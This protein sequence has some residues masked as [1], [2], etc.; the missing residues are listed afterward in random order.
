M[1]ETQRNVVDVGKL[2]II[3]RRFEVRKREACLWWGLC[4]RNEEEGIR[5]VC[6]VEDELEKRKNGNQWWDKVMKAE[7]S[8]C[9]C[10]WKW[11]EERLN[12]SDPPKWKKNS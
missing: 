7:G 2:Q 3:E 9:W 4:A 12:M 6:S 10:G 5:K 11:N 8:A 1:V